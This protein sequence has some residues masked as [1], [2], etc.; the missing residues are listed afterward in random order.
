MR[1]RDEVLRLLAKLLA[2]GP[3]E[4]FPKKQADRDVILALAAAGLTAGKSYE[5]REINDYLSAWLQGFAS[6]FGMDHVT[7]RRTLVDCGF[8]RRDPTGSAYTVNQEIVDH[9]LEPDARS[10]NPGEVKAE[11]DLAREARKRAHANKPD[12]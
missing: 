4:Q 7:V 8:L 1:T 6:P 3:I 2:N 10:I 11:L 5:E 9:T 12:A